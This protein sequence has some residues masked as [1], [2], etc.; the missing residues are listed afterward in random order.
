MLATMRGEVARIDAP[1]RIPAAAP[2]PV[3]RAITNRHH[4]RFTAQ[5]SLRAR[6]ALWAG[7]WHHIGFE[8][9]EIQRLF[10]YTFRVDALTAHAMGAAD[11]VNLQMRVDGE[12]VKLNIVEK[13]EQ[14]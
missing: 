12:I 3:A 14:T 8:D 6:M 5:Q 7:Y 13:G 10:F 9:R 2:P 1:V 4:E 11:A